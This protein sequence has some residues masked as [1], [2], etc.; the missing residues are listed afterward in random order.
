MASLHEA[1]GKS[2]T[3]IRTKDEL[4]RLF[5]DRCRRDQRVHTVKALLEYDL[6]NLKE[7][8]LRK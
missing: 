3:A 5:E 6:S 4:L 8:N 7:S 1:L 2:E